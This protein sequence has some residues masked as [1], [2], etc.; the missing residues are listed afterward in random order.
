MHY[1]I[2]DET[3]T[4]EIRK[5]VSQF[6]DELLQ[7]DDFDANIPDYRPEIMA[8]TTAIEIV[9]RKLMPQQAEVFITSVYGIIFQALMKVERDRK[10][11]RHRD[12]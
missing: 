3:I 6:M 2:T 8:Y 5:E 10:E 11:A 9:A 12:D 1:T 4:D 7:Y